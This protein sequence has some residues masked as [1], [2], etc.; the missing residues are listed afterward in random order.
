MLADVAQEVDRRQ[1]RGPVEVVDH[2]CGVRRPPKSRNGSICDRIRS[3]Q[4]ATV[5]RGVQRPLGARP[6]GSPISPVAPPTR[7]ERP[8]ARPLQAPHGQDLHQVADVQARRGRVEAAVERD[9]AGGERRAQRVLVGGLR[10]QAAPVQLVEDGG[11]VGSSV[12]TPICRLR[13]MCRSVRADR[14]G[15]RQARTATGSQLPRQ[16][17]I[18]GPADTCRARIGDRPTSR[19]GTVRVAAV[20][21]RSGRR[22]AQ[23]ARPAAP[24]RG[25]GR[26]TGGPTTG[27][28]RQL[29]SRRS[30]RRPAAAPP[31]P[32]R[33]A[34]HDVGA[35]V[36]A[37]GE[38][39]VEMTRRSEH[40][41]RARRR[42][43]ERVRAGIVLP[44]VGLDLGEPD[45]HGQL[46]RLEP[47]LDH[48]S[49][50]VAERPRGRDDRRTSAEPDQRATARS[51]APQ[52]RVIV[53]VLAQPSRAARRRA[54]GAVPPSAARASSAPR[55]VRTDRT[56]GVSAAR[57]LARSSS[58][59][60]QSSIAAL[61]AAADAGAR[62]S[63]APRGTARP[64]EPATRRRRWRARSPSGAAAA[65]R[66]V[67]KRSV[68]THAGHR[69]QHAA[70]SVSTASNDRLLVLL[71][72]AV[73]RE[74]QA[75]ERRE[76]ADE[77]ADQP[78][79]LAAGQLGDVGVLLLR[80][81]RRPGRV[82][83]VERRPAE[84]LRGPQARPP[85]RAAT[86]ARRSSRRR[87]GTR[88][89]SHGRSPRRSS[90]RTAASKPS[91][92]ATDSGRAA[93]TSRRGRRRRAAT[94]PR[95]GPSHAAGRRRG[96]SAC[97]CLASS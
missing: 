7:A 94:R 28:P 38:V 11:S 96:D 73:V 82:G 75:L 39:D 62:R 56:A 85:R 43:A 37:V 47:V 16:T 54:A 89:R 84:L 90:W 78:T 51:R 17:P 10:D 53:K 60:S 67:S 14:A 66:S 68:A 24:A 20:A 44:V 79:G 97:T 76:D 34:A 15:R 1:R 25:R 81:D 71:Q 48:P 21:H 19:T 49:E 74:R 41:R 52:A 92:V 6:L 40:H 35:P 36:H 61:V 87:T 12:T 26:R 23:S 3:T 42:P 30:P 33:L 80:H 50:Q 4:S 32:G 45:S 13:I 64:A 70:S 58:E 22:E 8:V 57:S 31:R 77:V 72:V 9:R 93:G 5:S 83:V 29:D 91:S 65:I 18:R 69:R 27:E 95:A 2:A 59:R 86:G 55:T 46:V 63:R 88:R